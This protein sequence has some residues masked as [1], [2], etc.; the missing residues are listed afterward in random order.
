MKKV[1]K[2]IKDVFV[3][4]TKYIEDILILG[5]LACIVRAT[6]LWS[7]IAGIYALGVSLFGL[8]VFFAKFPYK[9]R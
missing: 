7:E 3:L 9:R 5:G 2:R 6:F 8:G 4:T 1:I